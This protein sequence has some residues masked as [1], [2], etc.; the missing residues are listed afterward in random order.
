MQ[1][2]LFAISAA[3]TISNSFCATSTTTCSPAVNVAV[4]VTATAAHS[5]AS[6]S[7][8]S[9]APASYPSPTSFCHSICQ[10][11]LTVFSVFP[12][13]FRQLSLRAFVVYHCVRKEE[14]QAYVYVFNAELSK[15]GTGWHCCLDF[16]FTHC[17]HINEIGK[18]FI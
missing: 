8:P 17:L 15:T 11:F 16:L 12:R 13:Q 1:F 5:S 18:G 6:S 3:S 9:P 14:G 7:A 2:C 10:V 4:T